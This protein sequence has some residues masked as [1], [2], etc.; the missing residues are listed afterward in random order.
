MTHR[1][2]TITALLA[3]IAA[4]LVG[5]SGPKGP[6]DFDAFIKEP[7]PLVSGETYI[8][9]PPDVIEIDSKRVREIHRHRE[10]V[11]SD[12]MLTLPLLGSMF[13]AGKT[14]EQV[15]A[16]L[17]TRARE[18]YEDADVSLRV[19]GYNSQKVFVFGEVSA[20]GP[21][22]YTGANTVLS[23]MSAA[24]PS[25]LAN[26][27]DIRILRPT[28]EGKLAH[29]L[30]VDL[31]NM[32]KDGDTTLNA[33]LE[34]GDIVYVPP[35]GFAAVGLALQQLLLPIQPAASVMRGPTDIYSSYQS[36]PYSN[37]P[38]ATGGVQ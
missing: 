1:H 19:I 30:T 38:E 9:M 29:R 26:T 20:P 33:V 34:E 8:I 24:Q 32:V 18:F 5:C 13:V 12:G 15:S 3:A 4:T 28:D 7:R 17:Q 31:D 11:R 37:N 6:S 35:T 2:L 10:Q 27:S 16:E 22:P 23:L 14:T 36:Q 25:R 21:Y